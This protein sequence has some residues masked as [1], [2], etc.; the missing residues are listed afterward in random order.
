MLDDSDAPS[1]SGRAAEIYDTPAPVVLERGQTFFE[2]LYGKVSRRVMGQMDR[3][4]TGD[5]GLTARLMYGYILSNERVLDAKET[6]F[7]AMAG[8]IPQDVRIVKFP[9]NAKRVLTSW[10]AGESA[11][12]RASSG[13][14][15][16]RGH[17]R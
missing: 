8:L 10:R 4:G 9:H 13:S 5:L 6:S 15:Q 16:Q 2:R 12:E 14:S 17:D 3:S 7:V 11:V 1:P